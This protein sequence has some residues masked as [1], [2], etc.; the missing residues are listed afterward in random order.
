MQ[1]EIRTLG[2]GELHAPLAL[3]ERAA[4][5]VPPRTQRLILLEERLHL[6][7]KEIARS[8]CYSHSLSLFR[9]LRC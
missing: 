6:C 1:V 3:D 8:I 9:G 2:I 7:S 5:C 4:Q